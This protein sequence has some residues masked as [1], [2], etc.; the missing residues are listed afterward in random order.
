MSLP[1]PLLAAL[2]GGALIG[3]ST[4]GLAIWNGRMAGISGIVD[5]ALG[6][7]KAASWRLYFLAGLTLGGVVARLVAP[8][9]LGP[10]VASVPV[11]A[12]AGAL[13]GF[14]TRL[15]GGCTS[16]HGVCGIARVSKRSLA[17]TG[18]F[19]AVAAL[20]VCAVRRGV[21]W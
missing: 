5:G 7:G 16:G 14:G 19:M 15:S 13:V 10:V 2:M 18:V 21:G 9:A 8:E 4:A 12:V 3:L 11:L 20:V 17:A 1:M 6:G